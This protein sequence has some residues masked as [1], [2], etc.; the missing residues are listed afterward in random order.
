MTQK[1][2]EVKGILYKTQLRISLSHTL[3]RIPFGVYLEVLN[4]KYFL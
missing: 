3:R 2:F 4:K 1:L